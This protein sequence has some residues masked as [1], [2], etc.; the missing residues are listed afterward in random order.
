M[1]RYT[2]ERLIWLV[3][4][5]LT[6]SLITFLIMHAVPG[7]PLDLE[8]ERNPLPP[9]VRAEMAK[10]YGLDKPLWQQYLIFLK[11]A[12]QGNFGVSYIYKT[13]TVADIVSDGLPV[14]LQLGTIAM[15][16]GIIG[17]LTLGIIAAINR[18]GIMD[19]VCSFIAMLAI[20]LPSFVMAVFAII[21]FTFWLHL[22][23]TGGW[24]DT[25]PKFWILPAL[26]LGLGPLAVIAR[27]TRSSV[28]EAIGSDYVRTARAK[29]LHERRVVIVHVVKNAL[30]PV[31]TI[32][33][34]LF[35]AVATGSYFIESLFRVP[36][37]GRFFVLSMTN[38]DYSVIMAVVLL[39]GAFLAVMNLVVDLLYAVVDPRI[40]FG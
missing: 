31:I 37:L 20:S 40:R 25:N 14:S 13:R 28:V 19:Y 15:A 39:Y 8:P 4:T 35:A 2:L 36:G 1:L 6:I 33:G 11:N 10:N 23:P 30:I 18:N 24:S 38:R 27:Y 26:T 22:L 9:E 17:G 21:I 3:P 16:F 32:I 34:P 7:S 12:V 29:G 5:L